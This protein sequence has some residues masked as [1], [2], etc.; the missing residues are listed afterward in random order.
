MDFRKMAGKSQRTFQQYKPGMLFQDESRK[1]YQTGGKYKYEVL[2][3]ASTYFNA[4]MDIL[5]A[6]Q[7]AG[8]S[9]NKHPA[10]LAPSARRRA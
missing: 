4:R 10:K 1:Y 3:E 2:E 7:D 8:R 6:V 9:A 5:Q